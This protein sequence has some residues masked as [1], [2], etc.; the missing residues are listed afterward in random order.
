MKD[1]RET[2]RE[3]VDTYSYIKRDDGSY[4]HGNYWKGV[5]SVFVIKD[6]GYIDFRGID[7]TTRVRKYNKG[8]KLL[9]KSINNEYDY[10]HKVKRD[11][12]GNSQFIYN[13][14]EKLK[15]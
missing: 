9:F 4:I 12:N 1:K 10:A 11:I 15:Y 5:S 6:N 2:E 8:I 3:L 13:K 7:I 14:E